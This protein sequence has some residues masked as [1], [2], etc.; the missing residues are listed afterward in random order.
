M[1]YILTTT[2][3]ITTLIFAKQLLAGVPPDFDQLTGQQHADL[4]EHH[5]TFT[6][7]EPE[8]AAE[9]YWPVKLL[10]SNYQRRSYG[11]LDSYTNPYHYLVAPTGNYRWGEF[12]IRLKSPDSL[13]SL[14]TTYVTITVYIDFIT[15]WDGYRATGFDLREETVY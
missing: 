7:P 6:L 8:L 3:A 5:A 2:L 13:N 10:I 9:A 12:V 15:S 4:A 14:E 11:L 1:K